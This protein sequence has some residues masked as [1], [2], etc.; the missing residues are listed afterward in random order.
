MRSM[1][2]CAT[3]ALV[4]ASAASAQPEPEDGWPCIQR[5]VDHLSL[6]VMWPHPVPEES[7]APLEDDLRDVAARLAL[8]RVTEEE[9]RALVERVADEHPDLDLEGWG[10]IYRSAFERLDHDRT[11]IIRGIERYFDSQEALS[12]QIDELRAEM[13]RLEAIDDPT[14]AEFARMDAV[15]EELD[16]RIR[17][18]EE[19]DRSLTYVCESPVLLERRAYAVAQIILQ[20]AD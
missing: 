17:I 5:K 18:F 11:R 4:I 6:G 20:A 16:W 1:F 10:R 9:A 12:G 7:A 13:D 14:E 3:A 15:E 2:L 19:R 8:R